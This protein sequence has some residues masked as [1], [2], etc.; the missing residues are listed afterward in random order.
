MSK[1]VSFLRVSARG[2]AADPPIGVS[3]ADWSKEQWLEAM[4][5]NAQRINQKRKRKI[6][7]QPR[8]DQ[9][10]AGAST[11][12]WSNFIDPNFVSRSGRTKSNIV[13][14]HGKGISQGF[15]QYDQHLDE[16]F[17]TVD[18]VPAKK[19]RDKLPDG[20][21]RY[22]AKMKVMMGLTGDKVRGYSCNVVIPLWIANDP[23]VSGMIGPGDKIDG[24]PVDIIRPGLVVPFKGGIVGLLNQGGAMISS[25]KG[26]PETMLYENMRNNDFLAGL[27]DSVK[28]EKFTTGGA[29]HLDWV[30]DT[31]LG[32]CLEVQ[33]SEK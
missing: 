15:H 5:L 31:D 19:F 21:E 23:R 20:A 26:S 1:V 24:R 27:Q 14:Q 9:R 12:T 18:G 2:I 7:D 25:S 33:I 4:I 30:S 13:A 28:Y 22:A 29:S 6:P 8:Y 3:I 32:L 10:I 17:A 11:K 16:M